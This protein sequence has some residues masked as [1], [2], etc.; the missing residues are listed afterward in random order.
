MRACWI[1]TSYMFTT[2]QGFM[3]TAFLAVKPKRRTAPTYEEALGWAK[4]DAGPVVP[5]AAAK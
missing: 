1:D 5:G 4:W 2:M 3:E